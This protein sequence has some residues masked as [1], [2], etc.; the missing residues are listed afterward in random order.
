M[1]HVDNI[2]HILQHGITHRN[3]LI[4]NPKY[5]PIG[6]SSLIGNR[7]SKIITV[8]N[9]QYGYGHFQTITIGDFIPF[10]FGYRTPMLF[11]IQNGYN[12][13]RKQNPEKIVYCVIN[14]QNLINNGIPFYFT[15]GHATDSFSSCY[16]ASHINDVQTIVDFDATTERDWTRARDLKRKKEAELLAGADIPP[17]AIVGFACFNQSAKRQLLSYGI[18][19]R[20]IKVNSEKYFF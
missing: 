8:S 9:G 19:E 11:V 5:T 14:V 13:V 12:A 1:T 4:A 2:P 6:D 20:I 7:N 16:D 18:D 3:S 10:Y 17:N 15:N